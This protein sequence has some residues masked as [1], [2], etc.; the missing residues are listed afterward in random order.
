MLKIRAITFMTLLFSLSYVYAQNILIINNSNTRINYSQT[1]QHDYGTPGVNNNEPDLSSDG[2]SY[3]TGNNGYSGT[4]NSKQQQEIGSSEGY[5]W[6]YSTGRWYYQLSV[7]NG[8]S[9]QNDLFATIKAKY[10]WYHLYRQGNYI[11]GW[12]SS[13]AYNIPYSAA[14]TVW[15]GGINWTGTHN[16]TYVYFIT[17]AGTKPS[18]AEIK[19]YNLTKQNM[20]SQFLPYYP[21]GCSVGVNCSCIQDTASG[22]IWTTN[23]NGNV[24]ASNLSGMWSDWCSAN[25]NPGYD[26]NCASAKNSSGQINGNNGGP[27]LANT[28]TAGVCG[29][30]HGWHLPTISNNAAVNNNIIQYKNMNIGH[31]AAFALNNNYTSG[32]NLGEFLNNN[33]F[34]QI[35]TDPVSAMYWLSKSSNGNAFALD[36]DNVL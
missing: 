19:N 35:N 18:A 31:L 12:S 14:I 33:G 20:S 26:S 3:A 16:G 21:E 28:N 9:N 4:I 22:N 29:L 17:D 24:V 7:Q 23:N 25:N 5:D 1:V 11:N 27:Q 8:S 15:T 10:T 30:T 32:A 36:M 13:F 34:F 2:I 6:N